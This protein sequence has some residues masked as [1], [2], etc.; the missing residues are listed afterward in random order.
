MTWNQC[1]QAKWFELNQQL[2]SLSAERDAALA[3]LLMLINK[4]LDRA[5]E[6]PSILDSE[7]LCSAMLENVDALRDALEPFDSGYRAPKDAAS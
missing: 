4:C 5:D 6:T 7:A 3:E 2:A 1:K